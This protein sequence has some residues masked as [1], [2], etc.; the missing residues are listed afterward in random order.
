MLDKLIGPNATQTQHYVLIA[1]I[2]LGALYF[3]DRKS[4]V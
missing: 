3:L 2:L 4:V 1:S